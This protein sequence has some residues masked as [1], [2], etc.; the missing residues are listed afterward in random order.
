MDRGTRGLLNKREGERFEA[1][2]DGS[3]RWYSMNARAMIEKTPEPMK[4]IGRTGN[5]GQFAAVF[6]KAAQAD[7]SG[8]LRGGRSVRFEAKFTSGEK[9]EQSRVT[10][11]QAANLD[12]HEMMGAT[13]FVLAGFGSGGTVRAYRVPWEVWAKMPEI[14]GRKYVREDDLQPLRC[15]ITAA[16][17][18]FLK[19]EEEGL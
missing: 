5:P 16:G 18:M 19:A 17:I 8:T 6:T 15:K 11:E 3:C 4:V 10:E 13:C 14:F 1:L 2:I 12:A 9:M 7:Y